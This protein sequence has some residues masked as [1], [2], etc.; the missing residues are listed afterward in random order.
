MHSKVALLYI[1]YCSDILLDKRTRK[2]LIHLRVAEH[3]LIAWRIAYSC[4][5]EITDKAVDLN[6]AIAIKAKLYRDDQRDRDVQ[7]S[8]LCYKH[9]EGELMVQPMFYG[10]DEVLERELVWLQLNSLRR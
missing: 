4:H 9:K 10:S 1:L 5:Y 8:V 6:I 2:G 3:M 7:R